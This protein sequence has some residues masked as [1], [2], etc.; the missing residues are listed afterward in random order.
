MSQDHLDKPKFAINWE[1]SDWLNTSGYQCPS[2]ATVLTES[3]SG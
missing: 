1:Y 3:E 2:T